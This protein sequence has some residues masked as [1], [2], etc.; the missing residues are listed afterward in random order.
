MFLRILRS[1]LLQRI[2]LTTMF[3]LFVVTLPSEAQTTINKK[4]LLK[5]WI[6]E[7]YQEA[8]GKIYPASAEMQSDYLKYNSDGTME[9]TEEGKLVKGTWTFNEKTFS[10]TTIQNSN[11]NYPYKIETRIIKLTDKELVLEGKDAGGAK[12]IMYMMSK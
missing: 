8:D 9:S 2:Y 4:L 6:L 5:V 3:I 10:L 7:K 12:I 1:N 11:K